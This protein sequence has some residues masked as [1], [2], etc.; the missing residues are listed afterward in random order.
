MEGTS[1]HFLRGSNRKRS[2]LLHL[3][4]ESV[5]IIIPPYLSGLLEIRVVRI[6]SDIPDSSPV[7]IQYGLGPLEVPLDTRYRVSGMKSHDQ[8]ESLVNRWC[9]LLQDGPIARRCYRTECG[10]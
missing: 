3:S 8:I 7:Q 6:Q 2:H 5:I 4:I 9:N 10:G 1:E